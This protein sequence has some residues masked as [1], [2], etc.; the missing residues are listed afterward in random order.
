QLEVAERAVGFA[1]ARVVRV[2]YDLECVLREAVVP[3]VGCHPPRPSERLLLVPVR[4]RERDE[5][6][7]GVADTRPRDVDLD[8]CRERRGPKKRKHWHATRKP[9][10]L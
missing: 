5:A 2:P 7:A 3:Q 8:G 1:N 4:E 6:Q 10:K 9:R